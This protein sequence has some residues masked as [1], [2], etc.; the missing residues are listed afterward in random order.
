MF[1]DFDL[2]GANDLFTCNGHLEPDIVKA[3]SNQTYA[4]SPQFFWNTKSLSGPI[5]RTKVDRE[6]GLDIERPIVG[7]GAAFLDFNGDGIPDLVVTEHGGP[8]RL[9]EN[10]NRTGNHWIRLALRGDGV[11]SNRDAIGAEVEVVAG[12]QT[13]RWFVTGSR[14][15]LSQSELTVTVGLGKIKTIDRVV[16]RWPGRNMET[17]TWTSFTPNRE[18]RLLQGTEVAEILKARAK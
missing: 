8:A 13:R 3:Q 18:Y 9:F 14:G 10:R 7:R 11:S 16:V 12:G 2:D 6:V 1:C 5:F 17:Q 15:Y 4:Q